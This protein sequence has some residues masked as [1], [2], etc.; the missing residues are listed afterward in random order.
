MVEKHRGEP[1]DQPPQTPGERTIE[2]QQL[3]VDELTARLY[4]AE[5]VV[6]DETSLPESNPV[7]LQFTQVAGWP[8]EKLG[9]KYADMQ[10]EQGMQQGDVYG[11]RYHLAKMD[12]TIVACEDN[13]KPAC[14]RIERAAEFDPETGTFKK[15]MSREGDIARKLGLG[16]GTRKQLRY[17]DESKTLYLVPIDMG[18][19][20]V[21]PQTEVKPEMTVEEAHDML[22]GLLEPDES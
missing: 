17:L 4:M 10:T 9:S 13:G 2:L 18:E 15:P 5:V 16:H 3:P 11:I 7:R 19:A 8:A 22:E 1:G 21:V 14:V 12:Q 20:V 6:V